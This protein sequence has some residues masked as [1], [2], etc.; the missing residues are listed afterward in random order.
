MRDAYWSAKKIW[1]EEI[2]RKVDSKIIASLHQ[3]VNNNKGWKRNES[4]ERKYKIEQ[5]GCKG[6][7]FDM[8]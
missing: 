5:S 3:V 4:W 7:N 6:C 2:K 1:G 8:N